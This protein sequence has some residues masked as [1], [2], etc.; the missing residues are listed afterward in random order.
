MVEVPFADLEVSAD[1][2]QQHRSRLVQTLFNSKMDSKEW[3]QGQ[4]MDEVH[5]ILLVTLV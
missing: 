5:T 4:H 3:R 1:R 2:R